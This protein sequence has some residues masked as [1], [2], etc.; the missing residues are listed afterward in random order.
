MS[1]IT[2]ADGYESVTQEKISA[3]TRDDLLTIITREDR[4][5]ARCLCCDDLHVMYAEHMT[6]VGGNEA[7]EVRRSYRGGGSTR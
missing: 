2:Y 3:L 4:V 1:V 5:L 7:A 6:P